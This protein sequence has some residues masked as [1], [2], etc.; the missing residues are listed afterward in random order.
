M[1]HLQKDLQTKP[2]RSWGCSSCPRPEELGLERSDGKDPRIKP[3]SSSLSSPWVLWW[4]RN[5]EGERPWKWKWR[6]EMRFRSYMELKFFVFR[7]FQLQLTILD[8]FQECSTVVK[9]LCNLRRD[10]PDNSNTHLAPYKNWS[11]KLDW[12]DFQKLKMSGKL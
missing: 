11:F 8:E 7:F 4:K 12:A 1:Y 9:H 10:S 3:P 2:Q 6:E 5:D